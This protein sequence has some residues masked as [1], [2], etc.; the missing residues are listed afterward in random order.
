[1]D[2]SVQL[3]EK[4]G[5]SASKMLRDGGLVPAEFYGH[6]I[7]N[8]H[9]LVSE[10]DFTKA[11]KEAGT[12]TILYLHVNKES[13]ASHKSV[14]DKYTDAQEKKA[15]IIHDVVHD[16]LTGRIIHVDFYAVKM[17]EVITAK[18]PL[19]FI[20]ESPAVKEKGAIINKSMTEIEV[21]SLPQNL[22]HAF[23][24]DISLLDDL[25]KSI[26]VRDIKVPSGVK[27]L[28]EGDTVVAT[29][30]PPLVEEKPE[31]AVP[32]DVSAVKVEG[33]EKRVEREAGK[34]EAED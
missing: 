11:F 26:C 17:D 7:E 5:S 16:S 19:E 29:A 14:G 2:L 13:S 18:I 12:N 23:K 8:E 31:E 34:T 33:E 21:E 4:F 15:A 22:P 3:R 6:G 20:N 30:T 9:F 25:N 27:I 24:I 10:K 1:M 32:T 28:I